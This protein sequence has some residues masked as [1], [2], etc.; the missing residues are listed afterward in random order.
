MDVDSGYI[1]IEKFRGN[2][3]WYMME[4]KDIIPSNCFKRKNE[5]E[6]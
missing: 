3:Q 4:S 6:I 2:F 5:K 1:H